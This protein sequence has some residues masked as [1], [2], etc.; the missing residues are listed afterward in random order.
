MADRT[1]FKFNGKTPFT[2][3]LVPCLEDNY[4]YLLI[5]DATKLTIALDPVE[6]HKIT[7]ALQKHSCKLFAIALTHH[8]PDHSGG[9]VEMKKLFPDAIVYG[10][11]ERTPARTHPI[12]H[13]DIV[14][15][16]SMRLEAM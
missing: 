2:I 16:G 9:N 12:S 5:D 7:A 11:D 14:Q 13:K 10:F 6:P 8:H 15:M 3:V 1:V 4:A